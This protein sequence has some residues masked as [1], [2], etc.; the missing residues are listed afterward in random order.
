MDIILASNSPRRKELLKLLAEDFKIIPAK[1]EEKPD[2]SL[3]MGEM[4]ENI[5]KS[6]ALEVFAEHRDTIVIGADTMVF[7]DEIPLGKPKDKKDAFRTLKSLSGRSHTVATGVAIVKENYCDTF[8]TLTKVTFSK[9]TD[10]EIRWYID[11]LEPMDKAGSYGING[12][13]ALFI[14]KIEGDFYSV[15]GLPVHELKKHLEICGF[16]CLN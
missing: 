1:R 10:E 2:L 14:E 15:V 5:A 7:S 3:P 12:H 8:S 4:T 11:T 13:G 9:M 6:K 16:T